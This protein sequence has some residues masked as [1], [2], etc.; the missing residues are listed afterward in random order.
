MYIALVVIVEICEAF[1]LSSIAQGTDNLW[2]ANMPHVDQL[3][4]GEVF[5]CLKFDDLD[6]SGSNKTHSFSERISILEIVI[7]ETGRELVIRIL[8]VSFLCTP[9]P[10]TRL[11]E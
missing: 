5:V 1:N 6:F 9:S 11:V 8:D 4:N 10:P 2:L 7:I 3:H